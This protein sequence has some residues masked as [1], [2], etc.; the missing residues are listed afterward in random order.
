MRVKVA[1][2]KPAAVK[3]DNQGWVDGLAWPIDPDW[4]ARAGR[5]QRQIF[6]RCHLRSLCAA[7]L[8]LS[9]DAPGPLRLPKPER[10]DELGARR[11]HLQERD[12]AAR[13]ARG[14]KDHQA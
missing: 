10:A 6:N 14:R 8:G 1:D 7:R 11:R 5:L 3:I 2:D 13:R 12:A 4:K 9:E